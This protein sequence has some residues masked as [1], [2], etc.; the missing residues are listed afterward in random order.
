M[1][2]TLAILA[3][4]SIVLSRIVN[5]V[6]ADKIGLFQGTFFNYLTGFIGS[7]I[8]LLVSGETMKL[9]SINSYQ[10]SWWAY[11]GGIVG[12]GVIALSS[13]LSSKISAFYLTLLLFVGQLFGGM[14]LDYMVSNDFSI[15]KIIGGVLVV[16]GL[17]YNLWID[18][19]TNKASTEIEKNNQVSS[20]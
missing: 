1:Y 14:V 13:F 16:I 19:K 10:G 11:L 17:G 4:V 12:V 15:Q 9:F 20:I 5:Y 2:I 3:G 7:F 8:L 6:L 18:A